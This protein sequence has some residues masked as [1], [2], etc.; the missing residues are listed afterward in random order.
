MKKKLSIAICLVLAVSLTTGCT[1]FNNFKNAFFSDQSTDSVAKERTIK[2]GVYE[3]LTGEYRANGNEERVGI[4]LA[5]ELY[6]EAAGKRIELIYADNQGVMDVAETVIQ[7]LVAQKPS[8]ILGSYGETVTLTAGDAVKAN[9]IPAISITSTNPL[10]TVNNPYYFSA[11]FDQ[12]RQGD[13]I[14]DFVCT[15]QNLHKVVTVKMS[16]DDVATATVKRFTNRIKQL[17]ENNESVI[18]NYVLDVNSKDY[19]SVLEKIKDSGAEAVFLAVSPTTAQEFLK[20]AQE[21]KLTNILFVGGKS[22]NDEKFLKFVKESKT[23]N[24]AYA[25]DFSTDVKSTEMTEKFIK[26]YKDKYGQDKEPT[27]AMAIAFDAY[28]MAVEAINA[29]YENTMATDADVV[30]ENLTTDAAA[31]GEKENWEEAQKTGIPTGKAIREALTNINDF[32]GAS[33]VLSYEGNNEVR[34]T[35]VINH[36]LKGQVKEGYIVE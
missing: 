11:T 20:Q 10:I 12:T 8:V 26:A 32:E 3:P 25:S 28:L 1:T 19:S 2:I 29:A 9:N 35:V 17:T 13:A 18:G 36:I 6:P 24:I 23:F 16:G 21:A 14:A 27:E 22:W 33:G 4:E 7:E 30:V 31:K 5:N 34:K 15:A